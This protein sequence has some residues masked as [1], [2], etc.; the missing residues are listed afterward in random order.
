MEKLPD[1]FSMAEIM[2][3]VE[4]RTPYVVVAFQ[5]KF[6]FYFWE[7]LVYFLKV[8]FPC[9]LGV[10]ENEYTDQRNEKNFERVGFGIERRI[11]HHKWYGGSWKFII[12]WSGL[13]F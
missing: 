2:G 13:L 6:L 8:K 7:K 11:N 9:F 3:K 10:W 12:F 4:E 5:V 1:P